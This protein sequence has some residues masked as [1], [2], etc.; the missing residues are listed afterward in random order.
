MAFVILLYIVSLNVYYFVNWLMAMAHPE[1][2]KKSLISFASI[3]LEHYY[4]QVYFLNPSS[5]Y[6][7]GKSIFYCDLG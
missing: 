4:L 1:Y 2:E 3:L 7:F 5:G 6:F